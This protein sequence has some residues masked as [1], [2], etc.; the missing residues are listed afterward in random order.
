MT[1]VTCFKAISCE[2]NSDN[3]ILD[4]SL[5]VA[6][7]GAGQALNAS[8][9]APTFFPQLPVH[10]GSLV[11]EESFIGCIADL[12]TNGNTEGFRSELVLV[13]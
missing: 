13:S 7:V 11:G 9:S 1:S 4:C 12:A 6:G 3:G 2:V 8:H 10:F 5:S